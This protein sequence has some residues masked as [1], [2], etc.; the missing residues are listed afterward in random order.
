[1]MCRLGAAQMAM[2]EWEAAVAALEAGSALNPSSVEMVSWC[3]SCCQ[4]P[5]DPSLTSIAT[6][7]LTDATLCHDDAD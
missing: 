7:S 2:A 5:E 1:M 4:V 6:A 3:D